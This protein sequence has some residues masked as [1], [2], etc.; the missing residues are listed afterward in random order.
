MCITRPHAKRPLRSGPRRSMR[1]ATSTSCELRRSWRRCGRSWRRPSPLLFSGTTPACPARSA[2]SGRWR[3]RTQANKLT[4]EKNALTNKQRLFGAFVRSVATRCPGLQRTAL[5]RGVPRCIASYWV[6]TAVPAWSMQLPGPP[7][8]V[9]TTYFEARPAA[10]EQNVVDL[11][12][13]AQK[14]GLT[15]RIVS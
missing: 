2:S 7:Y 15:T 13:H 11:L 6:A 14:R 5:H 9:L 8:L 10:P 4:T 12:R 3:G 1:C